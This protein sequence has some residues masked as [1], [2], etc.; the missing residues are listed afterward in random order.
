MAVFDCETTDASAVAAE[1]PFEMDSRPLAMY[2][3]T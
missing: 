1:A 2:V 3:S